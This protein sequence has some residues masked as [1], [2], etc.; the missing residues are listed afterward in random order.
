MF[1]I[2]VEVKDAL[3]KVLEED[4]GLPHQQQVNQTKLPKLTQ[5]LVHKSADKAK[6]QRAPPLNIVLLE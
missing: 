1:L 3:D 5:L 4:S 6:K 2:V